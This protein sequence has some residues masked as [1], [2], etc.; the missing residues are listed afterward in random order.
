MAKSVFILGTGFIGGSVLA[1]LLDQ[2]DRYEI[3]AL[4]R[5]EKKAKK[6]EE[7]GVRPVMGELASDDVISK[8]AEQSDVSDQFRPDTSF[9][10]EKVLTPFAHRSSCTLRRPMTC[11]LSSPF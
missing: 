4:C 8:E 11:R 5:D 9:K 10:A 7:L 6:L 3:S 1:A 2:K